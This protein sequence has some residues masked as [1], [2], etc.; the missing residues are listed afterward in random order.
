MPLSPPAAR[1]L[2]H[3][4][5]VTCHGYQR[6]DGLWDIEGRIVDTKPYRFQNRDRGGW[7][8]ADEALHD[9]SIRL[10]ISLDL[11]V[12]D[13][14]AVIDHSPY[15]YCKSVAS[16]ARNLVGLKI[17]PGWTQKSKQAMGANRGCTHLTELLGPVATTAI[18]TIASARSRL[19]QKNSSR[20]VNAFLDS[21]HTYASD[22]PVVKLHWP[23]HYSG[24]IRD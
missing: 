8:E 3:T 7:I 9:I 21:C 16:I 17:A 22:S 2:A 6:D 24:E 20:S 18:Q 12:V 11:E 13:V 10:T 5:V 15:N 1:K 23:E 19:A 14:D 4:R